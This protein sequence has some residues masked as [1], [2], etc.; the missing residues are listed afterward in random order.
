M[1]HRTL[2]PRRPHP[3]TADLRLALP[4]PFPFRSPSCYHIAL[5]FPRPSFPFLSLLPQNG[6]YSD[7]FTTAVRT[8]GKAGDSHGI[9]FLLIPKGEGVTCRRMNM[10]GQWCAGTTY[11]TFEVRRRGVLLKLDGR[12]L[13][14]SPTSRTSRSRLRT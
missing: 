2:N 14:C 8:S 9:S 1:D 13:T 7:F 5:D 3:S 6:I 11:L 4:F 10:S 12:L